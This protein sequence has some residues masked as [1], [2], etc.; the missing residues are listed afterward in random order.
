MILDFMAESYWTLLSLSLS[1]SRERDSASTVSKQ[2][3]GERHRKRKAL[4]KTEGKILMGEFIQIAEAHQED[5]SRLCDLCSLLTHSVSV[6]VLP[7][8]RSSSTSMNGFMPMDSFTQ[9]SRVVAT[10]QL[11][12]QVTEYVARKESMHARY[13]RMKSIACKVTNGCTESNDSYTDETHNNLTEESY[14]DN[15]T[16]PLIEYHVGLCH[17][18][19]KSCFHSSLE[20]EAHA[21]DRHTYECRIVALAAL[22]ASISRLQKLNLALNPA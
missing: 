12:Q 17:R 13:D 2:N 8:D 4:M 19:M 14:L 15:K 11:R 5:M 20:Q 1:L 9:L 16:V 7:F 22:Q 18:A 10:S 6:L 3:R 21:I